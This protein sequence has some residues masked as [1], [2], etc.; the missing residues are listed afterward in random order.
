MALA[1]LG[2]HWVEEVLAGLTPLH[3]ILDCFGCHLV[4]GN[5]QLDFLSFLYWLALGRLRL[6]ARRLIARR[7]ALLRLALRHA[8]VRRLQ[9]LVAVVPWLSRLVGHWPP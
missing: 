8:A 5:L 2:V 4:I 7:R 1:S 6:L 9:P 3:P